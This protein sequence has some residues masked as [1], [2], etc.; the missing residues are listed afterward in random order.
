[1]TLL[2]VSLRHICGQWIDEIPKISVEEKIKNTR[3]RW[4]IH[5]RVNLYA[6]YIIL[7]CTSHF[8]TYAKDKF[9]LYLFCLFS[10]GNGINGSKGSLNNTAHNPIKLIH[11]K[12][13]SSD[14]IN[15][16]RFEHKNYKLI[17]AVDRNGRLI[18][19]VT[20]YVPIESKDAHK[21]PKRM[22]YKWV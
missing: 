18:P 2:T 14:H 9:R 11:R 4:E 17:D 7:P 5:L 19:F 10:V 22:V 13:I 1:M 8:C 15:E 12:S 20:I 16:E 6:K 21:D 3:Y